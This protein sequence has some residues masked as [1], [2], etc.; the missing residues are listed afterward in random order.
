MESDHDSAPEEQPS[1]KTKSRWL[2]LFFVVVFV[3]LFFV[4]TYVIYVLVVVQAAFALITGHPNERLLAAGGAL[5][6]YTY[7]LLDYVSY[8]TTERPFPLSDWP[9]AAALTKQEA[10]LFDNDDPIDP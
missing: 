8:N 9:D 7:Q 4:T 5:R 10:Q 2:Q 6:N 1:W 3:V